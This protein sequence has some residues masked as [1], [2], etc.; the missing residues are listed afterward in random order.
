MSDDWTPAAE[1]RRLVDQV[2]A[3]AFSAMLRH[4]ECTHLTLEISGAT[5]CHEATLSAVINAEDFVSFISI[6]DQLPLPVEDLRARLMSDLQD[7]IAEGTSTWGEL[8]PVVSPDSPPDCLSP[9]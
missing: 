7:F 2:I 8:R 3:P 6:P 5:R 4:G 9:G 1:M